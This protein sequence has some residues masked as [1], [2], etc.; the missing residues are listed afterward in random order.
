MIKSMHKIF[1]Y[2]EV[3]MWHSK[4]F[5]SQR[6]QLNVEIYM[7]VIRGFCNGKQCASWQQTLDENLIIVNMH[8]DDNYLVIQ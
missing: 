2:Q 1:A 6:Q 5:L 3:K 8:V 7:L 4:P